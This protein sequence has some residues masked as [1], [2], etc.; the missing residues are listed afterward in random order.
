M[1]NDYTKQINVKLT[2][3]QYDKL[4]KKVKESGMSR[5]DFLRDAIDQYVSK[6]EKYESALEELSNKY[7]KDISVLTETILKQENLINFT[8]DKLEQIL[9]NQQLNNLMID[10]QSQQRMLEQILENQEK[11]KDNKDKSWFSRLFSN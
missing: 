5:S 4:N 3:E 10:Y 2:E 11:E 6:D 7:T 8:N 1:R 9:D